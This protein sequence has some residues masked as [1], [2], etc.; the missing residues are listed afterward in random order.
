MQMACKGH[1][2]ATETLF[3]GPNSK[4]VVEVILW[5]ELLLTTTQKQLSAK[6][7]T[8]GHKGHDGVSNH[9]PHDC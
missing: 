1:V 7:I 2:P 6:Y 9:E 4:I 3:S 8:V 5:I